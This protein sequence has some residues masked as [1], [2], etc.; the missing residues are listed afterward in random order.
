MPVAF[1]QKNDLKYSIIP[2]GIGEKMA[3]DSRKDFILSTISN[4][5]GYSVTDGAVAHIPDSKELN[6]FLD[7]GNCPLLAARPEL[8]QG[9][10]LIQVSS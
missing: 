3:G 10:K 2:Q 4:H 8:T 6:S 1:C 5:F 7:D 9:I